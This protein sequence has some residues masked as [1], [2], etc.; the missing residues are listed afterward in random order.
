MTLY[1]GQGKWYK[2]NLNNI[3]ELSLDINL[4]GSEE[5]AWKKSIKS[6]IELTLL[7]NNI[8]L[9]LG[10]PMPKLILDIE[11]IDSSVEHTSSYMVDFSIY[12]YGLSEQKYSKAYGDSSLVKR[13]GIYR[14]YSQEILGQSTSSRV[15]KDIETAIRK[16]MNLLINQWYKDNPTKSL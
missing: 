12:D 4:K 6:Y 13:M 2:G 7:Q 5:A 3:E 14:I 10:K 9:T 11:V 16:C 15:Y 1:S 8:P